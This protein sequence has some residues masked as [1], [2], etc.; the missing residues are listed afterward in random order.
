MGSPNPRTPRP[1]L[2]ALA[3][4]LL[5]APLAAQTGT[6]HGTVTQNGSGRPLA[7]A[8]V[9]VTG[10]TRAAV[11]DA[12]GRYRLTELPAG[13]AN[14]RATVLG[15]GAA[16]RTVSVA[17][18]GDT[19]ANFTLVE[20]ALA[21]DAVI[22]TGTPGAVQRRTVGNAVTRVD[23]EQVTRQ[24]NVM[25]I[26]EVLQARSPGVTIL[27]NAGTAGTAADIRIRGAGSLLGYAP[28]VYV[29]GV[30]YNTESLGNFSPA[31]AGLTA[32]NSFQTTSGFN[33]I[34]P[35]DIESIEVIKGPA[36]ATLYGAEA[37]GGVIQI[38]TKKGARG[39]QSTRWD[40]RAEV[41]RNNWQ[42]EPPTN[43]TTCDSLK[44][45]QRDAA[46]NPVWPGCQSVTRGTV[47]TDNPLRRDPNALRVGDVRRLSAS[48][49]GGGDRFSYFVS[50]DADMEEGV[51]RNNFSRRRSARANF[52]VSPMRVLE[53]A[54]TSNF[55][56]NKIR[57]PY[58]DES[59]NG[60][61]LSAVRGRPGRVSTV[62]EGWAT[63]NPLQSN[64]YRNLTSSDRVIL[65]GTGN[66][67]PREWFRNR[68]TVGLDFSSNLAELLSEP[69][70]AD[71]PS[72]LAAQRMPRQHIYTLD[73]A[74]NIVRD[75]S[76]ALEST[77]SFGVQVTAK[78]YA[79]LFASGTGLGAPDVT[80][81]GTAQTISGS[82]TF[83]AN[84]SVGYFVQQQV[85]LHNRLFLTGALRADD[86]SSFGRDFNVIVYPKASLSWVVSEE[87]A[88]QGF[89]N[90]FSADNF[91]L[92]AAWGQAGRAPDPY[93][94]TQTYTI[95]RVTLANGSTGSA[96]R[97]NAFGNPD[98]RAERGQE[99]E[100]GFDAAFF[101]GRGSLEATYYNKRMKDVIVS[102]FVPGS[103]GFG[104]GNTTPAIAS[105]LENLGET[106]NYGVEVGLGVTPVQRRAFTWE[107]R[108]N[109][110]TNRNR[111]VSFGD[112]TRIKD[113]PFQAYNSSGL[114]SAVHQ[115]HRAGYP[116][117]GY[118]A[119]LPARNADGSYVLNAAGTGV[120]LDTAFVFAGT[121]SPTREVSF[122]NTF[123]LFGNLRL[124]ALLDHKGGFYL[125]NFKEFNRCQSNGNCQTV[126]NPN[127]TPIDRALA[128][129]NPLQYLERAD[130][131]KLRDLSLTYALPRRLAAR[132]G[133]G[134]ASVTLA[135]HNLALWTDYSGIDPEVN[136][137]ANRNFTRVDAYAA[138]M[139]RR[140]TVSLNLGF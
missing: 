40:L 42:L 102:T 103:T 22:V 132:A 45:V 120:V 126:N 50:G 67:R 79:T 111:L 55:L 112:P 19:Q 107:S 130:F 57:L 34:N 84:N 23:V 80:L 69:G 56:S 18:G 7:G 11:T 95:D 20:Q 133:A 3:A 9:E 36:A 47:L 96:L 74:G 53:F 108:L 44:Q 21:L 90:R 32:N 105:R 117:G 94:A 59:A 51:F 85:A 136:T 76:G 73:Y 24:T 38:I 114:A 75:L 2:A 43:Y 121:A 60:L 129:S 10:T 70:A 66:Y 104:V 48:V 4:L 5:G 78:Q 37:A 63:I 72:G 140:V 61:L 137:Y 118:W 68:L 128:V 12:A 6:V 119:Q 65:S 110:S 127:I 41:G 15:H 91:K 29:D 71:V 26:T 115:E 109:L 52:T 8:R 138:P 31:G 58:G 106:L 13:T 28:V 64:E 88:L 89:F 49:R 101:G 125:Y 27:P 54:F 16:T 122:S 131:V 87:P 81:I 1:W 99:L 92:R 139:M 97:V 62:G 17:A 33:G 93:S 82:N 135:G 46:N 123:T 116:L 35:E 39:Q 124:Y 86:N 134:S 113:V 100:A 83:S 25:N 14:L 98:L 77:T 30:R